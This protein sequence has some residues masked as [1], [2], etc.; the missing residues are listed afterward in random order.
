MIRHIVMFKLRQFNSEDEKQAMLQ[1]LKTRIEKLP[2]KI[3]FIRSMEVGINLRNHPSAYDLVLTSTFDNLED[4]EKY[5]VHPAHVE[6]INFNKDK[7][8]AKSSVD[9]EI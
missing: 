7:S 9:F 8:I 2:S 5:T 1:Q 4:V 3:D 6:F